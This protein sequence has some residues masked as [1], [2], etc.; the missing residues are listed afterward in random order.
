M[1]ELDTAL[2]ELKAGTAPGPSGIGNDSIR[3]LVKLVGA[4][5]FLLN[6]FNGCLMGGSVPE[7]WGHCE[8]FILYKGKGDPLVP[9]SYRA[10]ALLD[11][12]MKIYERLLFHRLEGWAR[13]LE[14]I[15]PSQFGF[16]TGSGT[17]Y[18]VFVFWRL[19]DWFVR[20]KRAVL[21]TAL[22]DFKSAFPSVDRT[23]LFSC[24]ASLGLSR[25]FGCALH[26]LFEK[27]TFCLRLGE[28]VTREFPVTTGLREGSVLSP[29][30]FSIFISDL[31]EEVL[32]PFGP[33]EFLLRDCV[34][35]GVVVNGLMFA[36][37]LVIFARSERAL[38][39]RLKRLESYVK[40]R[41]LTV[42]V[43]KCEVV[44][45]GTSPDATF[46]FS[47]GGG[48]LPVVR[49]CKY[50]GVWF[51]RDSTLAAHFD[52]LLAQFK[53]AVGTFF[54]LGKYLKLSDLKTWSSLQQSLLFSVLYGL[55]F[56]EWGNSCQ[57]F[58]TVYFKA[59]R[60]YLG[61]PTHVSNHVLSLLFPEFSMRFLYLKKKHGF[62]RRMLRPCR[63][64]ASVFFLH[65]RAT[66][67]PGA[68]GFCYDLHVALKAAGVEELIWT[69][70]TGLASMALEGC[71]SQ[72][73]DETWR[74][75][76]QAKST[77]FLCSVFGSRSAWYDFLCFVSTKGLFAVRICLLSWTGSLGVALMKH[78]VNSCPFCR[79]Y[80]DSR[81]YFMC[82]KPISHQLTVISAAR[83]SRFAEL[84]SLTLNMYFSFSGR[85][86]LA[87]FAEEEAYLFNSLD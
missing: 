66:S 54:R 67:F 55:E 23:L 61:V 30:L 4:K 79:G 70:D 34:F 82:S 52:H 42:N 12:F 18:A 65:D 32:A 17:L 6:L 3:E 27:N 49:Q 29:L 74:L 56:E 58:E 40:A 16:R 75:M 85:F 11:A 48:Q 28:G 5:R 57:Q 44:A 19:V 81:H 80:L 22:I 35:D 39:A 87:P 38:R 83:N 45:F 41:K 37:D 31:E 50:L 47:F 51:D 71:Q 14:L 21:F 13:D 84:W 24:L 26:S 7:A 62:M 46:K 69:T 59:L 25:K 33:R 78:K 73:S 76:V 72:W 2:S 20:K 53:N 68:S 77:R 43:S 86:R 1:A 9:S 63:T 8:M 15:P 64:L 60:S 10:I 36:D